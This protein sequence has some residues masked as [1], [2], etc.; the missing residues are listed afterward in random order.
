MP[1]RRTSSRWA[2]RTPAK[3]IPQAALPSSTRAPFGRHNRQHARWS[4]TR[5]IGS[6]LVTVQNDART[7]LPLRSESVCGDLTCSLRCSLRQGH[8]PAPRQRTARQEPPSTENPARRSTTTSR[9]VPQALDTSLRHRDSVHIPYMGMNLSH[10]A[11]R[12]TPWWTV[13]NAAFLPGKSCSVT[14][15]GAP[16]MS[17]T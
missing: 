4:L 9:A 2:E 14:P 12:L 15:R 1:R 6:V 11:I 3:P 7:S 13:R 5:E 16:Q 8:S 17:H 10:S